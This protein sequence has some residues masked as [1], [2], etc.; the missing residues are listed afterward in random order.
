[1]IKRAKNWVFD[2]FREFGQLDRLDIVYYE[3]IICFQHIFCIT[4]SRAIIEKSKKMHLWMM[5]RVKNE[6]FCNFLQ[7]GASDRLQIEYESQNV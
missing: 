1:M 4:E 7:L 5:Q 2:H 6:V 3:R